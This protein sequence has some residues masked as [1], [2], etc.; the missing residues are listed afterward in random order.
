MGV[1]Q[2][3][4]A[5]GF[6][7]LSRTALESNLYNFNG[8]SKLVDLIKI[9]LDHNRSNPVKFV[10][11]G[12]VISVYVKEPMPQF[13]GLTLNRTTVINFL[14][15]NIASMDLIIYAT[16]GDINTNINIAK[17]YKLKTKHGLVRYNKTF[18]TS[19]TVLDIIKE[20]KNKIIDLTNNRLNHIKSINDVKDKFKDFPICI[21]IS[22]L[23]FKK[24]SKPVQQYHVPQDFESIAYRSPTLDLDGNNLP[25]IEFTYNKIANTVT[26]RWKS[27]RKNSWQNITPRIYRFKNELSQKKLFEFVSSK[28]NEPIKRYSMIQDQ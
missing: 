20:N 7:V 6:T 28:L 27:A 11:D 14:F 24:H 19:S 26:I 8:R 18:L 10:A 3:A 22:G 2:I 25:L 4:K 5:N 13:D 17:C 21:K 1:K 12:V 16:T 9:D 23:N 15:P